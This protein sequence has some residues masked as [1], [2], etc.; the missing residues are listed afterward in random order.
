MRNTRSLS[1]SWESI[2]KKPVFCAASP[3]RTIVHTCYDLTHVEYCPSNHSTCTTHYGN[4]RLVYMAGGNISDTREDAST[5]KE[6][7]R[8][9]FSQIEV[10]NEGRCCTIRSR[11]WGKSKE[12][13][14]RSRCAIGI[15]LTPLTKLHNGDQ[16]SHNLVNIRHYAMDLHTC[17]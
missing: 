4:M 5:P 13:Y 7:K 8:L 9:L 17:P 3:L 1:E 12:Q 14:Y 11:S 15:S 10:S 6:G 16:I 2:H